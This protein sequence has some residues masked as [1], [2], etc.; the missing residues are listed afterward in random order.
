M[1]IIFFQ[2]PIQIFLDWLIS[3]LVPILVSAFAILIGYI[4]YRIAKRE[5]RRMT[6]RHKIEQ[7]TAKNLARIRK[8]IVYLVV[9]SAIIS[10]FAES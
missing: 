6:K 9:I 7:Q 2:N 1:R 4:L 5:I 3:N 10:Q 8:I